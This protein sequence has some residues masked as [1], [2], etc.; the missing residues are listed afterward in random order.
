M[1]AAYSNLISFAI[2][3]AL[4]YYYSVKVFPVRNDWAGVAVI[5]G[6]SGLFYFIFAVLVKEIILIRAFAFVLFISVIAVYLR[7]KE[8]V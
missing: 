1:G 4:T 8:V 5:I 3:G 7:K 2:M 6:I